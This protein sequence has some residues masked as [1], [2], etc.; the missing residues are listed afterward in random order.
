MYVCMYVCKRAIKSESKHV[1]NMHVQDLHF[2]DWRVAYKIG[3]T[4]QVFVKPV[5]EIWLH[6]FCLYWTT[7]RA[8]N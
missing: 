1:C 6:I 2:I 4:K 8:G 3:N 5:I 7:F